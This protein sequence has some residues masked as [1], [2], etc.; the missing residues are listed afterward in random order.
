M[1]A[2]VLYFIF[3]AIVP[4]HCVLHAL[5]MHHVAVRDMARGRHDVAAGGFVDVVFED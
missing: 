1:A 3:G 2:L 5:E 4:W